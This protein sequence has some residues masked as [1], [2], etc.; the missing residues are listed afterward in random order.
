MDLQTFC[1][2]HDIPH[3]TVFRHVRKFVSQAHANLEEIDLSEEEL[4]LDLTEY[5]LRARQGAGGSRLKYDI[6][7][8]RLLAREIQKSRGVNTIGPD[9]ISLLCKVAQFTLDLLYQKNEEYSVRNK[10]GYMFNPNAEY[11]DEVKNVIE[12]ANLLIYGK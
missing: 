12:D 9:Q 1:N 7:D 11:W 3:S 8:A 10:S 2:K 6:Y 5:G 4:N